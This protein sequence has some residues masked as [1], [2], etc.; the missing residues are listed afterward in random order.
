MR[1]SSE[2]INIAA[3]AQRLDVD[4][5]IPLRFYCRIADNI[6][7]Q[8]DIFREEKN[9]IDLY[10]MLLRFSSLV[11]ETIPRHR[12]Y[13][14]SLQSNKVYLNKKLLIAVSE[15]EELKP[16]VQQRINELNRKH[17][18]QNNLLESPSVKKVTL[19]NYDRTE[20]LRPASQEFG[21]QG[22]TAQQLSHARTVDEQFRRMSLN[23]PRPSAETLSRHSILGPNGLNGH[24]QPA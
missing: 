10:V 17:T 15:L 1:S 8:A 12:D 6:L 20:A 13:R 5:R 22:S 9:I 16:A 11:M 21:Y 23:F 4:Y 3:F 14:A 7:K 19:T 18:A 24:W 2:K